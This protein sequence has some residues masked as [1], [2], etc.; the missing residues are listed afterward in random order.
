MPGRE[1]D[2]RTQAIVEQIVRGKMAQKMGC[3]IAFFLRVR[4]AGF[5]ASRP[6][7]TSKRANWSK[8]NKTGIRSADT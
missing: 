6:C 4:I 7:A 2:T 1:S 8:F 5:S 3:I